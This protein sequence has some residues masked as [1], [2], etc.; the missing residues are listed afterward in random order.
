MRLEVNVN[1]RGTEAKRDTPNRR[2]RDHN[3]NRTHAR[4]GNASLVVLMQDWK[5]KG[6]T[7]QYTIEVLRRGGQHKRNSEKKNVR[8]EYGA[9]RWMTMSKNVIL[10]M[11]R[12][13]Q[14]TSL[15][16]TEDRKHKGN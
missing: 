4:M 3:R 12:R 7:E 1:N 9:K 11:F 8:L 5:N 16:K 10:N 15:L 6:S 2:E 13:E 14:E